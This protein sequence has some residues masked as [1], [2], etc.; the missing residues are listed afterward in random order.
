MP[1]TADEVVV[2]EIYAAR[3]NFD[4]TIKSEDLVEK[5]V[6]N[7]VNAKYIKDFPETCAYIQSILEENDT[8]ITTGCGNPHL[9]AYMIAGVEEKA[10]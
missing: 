6:A 9:L 3:E 2:T 8:V 4:P 10:V 5:L 7:G 1:F